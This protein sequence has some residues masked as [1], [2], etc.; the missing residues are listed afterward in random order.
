MTS[1]PFY[2]IV[3]SQAYP[4]SLPID[5]CNIICSVKLKQMYIKL[6][7]LFSPHVSHHNNYVYST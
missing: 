3:S 2:L 6:S 7:V 5:Q 1:W 4:Q